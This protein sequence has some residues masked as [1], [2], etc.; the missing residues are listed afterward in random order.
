MEVG[1]WLIEVS[2]PLSIYTDLSAEDLKY[3]EN[4]PLLLA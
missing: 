1:K 3:T 2:Q 4:G